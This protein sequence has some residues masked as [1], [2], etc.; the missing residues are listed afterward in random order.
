[1]A[2]T[3][4]VTFGFFASKSLTVWSQKALPGPVVELCQKV[5][6]TLPPSLEA[7]LPAE[8]PA[9]VRAVAPISAMAAAARIFLVIV[10][11]LG[12]VVDVRQRMPLRRACQA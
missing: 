10:E 1:M 7:S 8:Q 5:M 6:V 9:A 2:W 4:I 3:L 11:L 12:V